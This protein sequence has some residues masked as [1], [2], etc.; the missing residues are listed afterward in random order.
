MLLQACLGLDVDGVAG[1]VVLHRP[2]LPP[3]IDHLHIAG[4][5]VG[6]TAHTELV[7]ERGRDGVARVVH[8][9]GAPVVMV[10]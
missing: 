9:T 1:R 4:L 7:V 6:A 8:S 5:E 10:R 2:H 3:E